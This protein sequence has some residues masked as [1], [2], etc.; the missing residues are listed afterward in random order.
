[1]ARTLLRK[2]VENG[3]LKASELHSRQALYTPAVVAEKPVAVA[4][5]AK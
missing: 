2:C 3:S 1:V 4:A 5:E